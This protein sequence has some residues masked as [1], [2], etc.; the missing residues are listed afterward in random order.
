[1]QV[2]KQLQKFRSTVQR[3]RT[4]VA[5]FGVLALAGGLVVNSFIQ[6]SVMPQH[7][8]PSLPDVVMPAAG[9]KVL[10]F[11]PHPDDETIAVGGFIAMSVKNGADVRI[12]LV[13]DGNRHNNEI[14][15]YSEFYTITA[16]LGVKQSNLI[17]LGLNDGRLRNMKP[18]MLY[19]LLKEQMDTCNPDIV[20]YPHPKDAHP[21][22][23]AIGKSVAEIL[24]AGPVK[25][26]AYQ[27]LVHY[28]ILYPEPVD[29]NTSLYLLPPK[30]LL[31]YDKEWQ[32]VMLPQD[33]EDLKVSAVFSYRSQLSNLELRNLMLSFI[34]R[35]ELLAVPAE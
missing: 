13:T 6:P 33:I 27:Y 23:S 30:N 10:V 22:H 32:R 19:T 34:R 16:A 2:R 7:S 4:L 12:V 28:K 18:E 15:R 14:K 1:M 3:R 25:R 8:I 26:T 35:N 9:Q 29:F 5:L 21:D 17:F 24:K 31:K 11:S 20:I